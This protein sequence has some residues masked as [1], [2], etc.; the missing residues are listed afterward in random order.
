MAESANVAAVRRFVDAFNRR[1]ISEVLGDADSNIQ[2]DEW[3]E[4]PGSRSYH[5]PEGVREALDTWFE[6][7]EW[8]HVEIEELREVG[9]CVFFTLHQRAKGSTSG[10]EVEIKSW[11]VYTFGEGRLTRIQLF[12]D[13]DQ[14]LDA[15]GLTPDYDKEQA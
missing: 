13:R 2:L 1:E 3:P 5:G 10:I 7:W 11:N 9:D 14:A 4:A 12:L 8:M 15:A 6:T